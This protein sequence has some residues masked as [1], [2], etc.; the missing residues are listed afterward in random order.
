MDRLPGKNPLVTDTLYRM[1]TALG[2]G[3]FDVVD[4][5]SADPD[6]IGIASPIDHR[7]LVYI[8]VYDDGYFVELEQA[9]RPG[10]DFPYEV[11]GR[12]SGLNFEELV[13]V[14]AGHLA[15]GT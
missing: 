13:G 1:G 11:V 14:V 4:H 8:A 5:W 10:D 2:V 3:A 7:V 9:P 15:R 12:H 6:A